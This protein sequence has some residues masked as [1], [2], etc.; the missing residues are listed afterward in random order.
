L[1]NNYCPDRLVAKAIIKC[2][3]MGSVDIY[4]RLSPVTN[5]TFLAAIRATIGPRKCRGILLFLKSKGYNPLGDH[6]HRPLLGRRLQYLPYMLFRLSKLALP[7]IRRCCWC[8]VYL[9]RSSIALAGSRSVLFSL[10]TYLSPQLICTV[11]WSKFQP[12]T[13]YPG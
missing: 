2:D 9:V 10:A 3:W 4:S 6:Y 5:P 1:L 7:K 13:R 8:S 11:F 12:H